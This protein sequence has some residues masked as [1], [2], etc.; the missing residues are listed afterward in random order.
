MIPRLIIGND[1]LDAY[2][3]H[4]A[5]GRPQRGGVAF[6]S[7]EELVDEAEHR[8]RSLGALIRVALR[9][10]DDVQDVGSN[11]ATIVHRAFHM[12]IRPKAG[13]A[14]TLGPPAS[15][16]AGTQQAE[17]VKLDPADIVGNSIVA[18]VGVAAVSYQTVETARKAFRR[19]KRG[20]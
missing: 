8:D 15:Q 10:A 14:L 20:K 5:P 18:A 17:H 6:P 16:S 2:I 9:K 11:V 3:D 12:T 1:A 4:I 7:G 13:G 19:R